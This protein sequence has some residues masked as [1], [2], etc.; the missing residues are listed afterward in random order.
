MIQHCLLL[1]AN[2][3]NPFA[4]YTVIIGNHNQVLRLDYL[5][6]Y[7]DETKY[8]FP[9][10]YRKPNYSVRISYP[11]IKIQETPYTSSISSMMQQT[12]TAFQPTDFLLPS[13]TPNNTAHPTENTLPNIMRAFPNSHFPIA[14]PI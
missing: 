14:R 2:E 4:T 9:T 11:T 7:L 13:I 5:D 3:M 10:H 6:N 12:T 8:S 1:A